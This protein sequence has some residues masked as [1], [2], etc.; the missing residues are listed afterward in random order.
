[1]DFPYLQ[2]IATSRDMISEFRGYNHT[3][4][5]QDGEFYDMENMTSDLY[6]IAATRQPRGLYASPEKASGLIS[7][8]SL[9]YVDGSDFVINQYHVDMGLSDEPKT[10]VSMGAYVIILPDK[11]YFNTKDF[12]D[13]G[14]IE[15]YTQSSGTVKLD[16]CRI[17]GELYEDAVRSPT[18]PEEPK[19]M[20]LWIDTSTTP[21]ALKQFSEQS[22]LWVTIA[23]TYI[24]ISSTGIG[25][26]FEKHDGV[27]ISG[28]PDELKELNGNFVIWEKGDDYLVITGMLSESKDLVQ[29]IT[30]ERKMPDMDFVIES[31]NRLWGCRYGLSAGKTV[32]NE[33]YASKLGDFKNWYCFMGISTDSYS[34]SLGSDGQFTG[35]ITHLG[36]PLFFK[37]GCLHKIYGSMPSSFQVQTTACRGVQKGSEKSLAIVNELLYYKSSLGICV[38]D[39]SLPREISGNL[40][41]VY[42]EKAVAG[43]HGNKYFVS[44]ADKEGVYS[45]FAFDSAKGMWHR[46]DSTQAKEFCSCRNVMYYLDSD[47]KIKYFGGDDDTPIQWALET[48]IIGANSPDQKYLSKVTM[49]LSMKPGS[50]MEVFAQYDSESQWHSV[51]SVTAKTLRSFTIP[52][53]PRRCDHMRLKLEGS[54]EI[55]LFSIAKTIEDGSDVHVAIT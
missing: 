50:T 39:G 44:M 10:M 20:A 42:Y 36:Y 29:A 16:L 30:I 28:M 31:G 26:N 27:V 40:G 5:I 13:F 4:R 23:T 7:K 37:E 45:L 41:D 9:C 35:A 18:P 22:G 21:N 3:Q 51:A 14:V 46:E 6:P 53:R 43:G 34:V 55:K 15:A 48:G 2:E 32:V 19:N 33:I 12:D 8:D 49:R 11:K 38:Y 52:I 54:G 47:G 24:K 1:M 17:N 25:L